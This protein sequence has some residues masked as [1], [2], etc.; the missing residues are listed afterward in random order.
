MRSSAR[1]DPESVAVNPPGPQLAGD[2]STEHAREDHE[3]EDEEQGALGAE[4]SDM[5]LSEQQ[6]MYKCQVIAK[7]S[8]WPTGSAQPPREGNACANC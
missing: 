3:Q 8:A 5:A 7:F 1:A 4:Q 2:R 6:Y